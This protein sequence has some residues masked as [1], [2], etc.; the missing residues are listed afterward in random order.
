M[1]ELKLTNNPSSVATPEATR[2]TLYAVGDKLYY[3]DDA[4]N[5][6]G[7]LDAATAAYWFEKSLDLIHTTGSIE[8]T[9]SLAQGDGAQAAGLYTHAE[10][11]QTF[12]TGSYTHAE[13]EQTRAG[14]MGYLLDAATPVLPDGSDFVW[15]LDASYGNI[16]GTINSEF[17]DQGGRFQTDL[18]IYTF[19]TAS[20]NGTNTVITGSVISGVAAPGIGSTPT[21]IT[22]WGAVPPVGAD[23]QM[24]NYSHAEG[25][26]AYTLG[27]RSHAEGDGGGAAVLAIA[28]GAHAEGRRAVAAGI[29]SHAEGDT[30]IASGNGSHSEGVQVKASG[31]YSH[32]EGGDT[33]SYGHESHAEGYETRSGWLGYQ[34]IGSAPDGGDYAFQLDSSYQD[35]TAVIGAQFPDANGN[36]HTD[37]GQYTYVNTSW[38]GTNT[39]ITGSGTPP[40]SPSTVTRI[41]ASPPSRAYISMGFYSH[42]EGNS[43]IAFG[44]GSHAEGNGTIALGLYSHAEG[45]SGGPGSLIASGEYAHAEGYN[46][47]ASGEYSHAEGYYS[48]ASGPTSH[49]EGI[50]T[51][52]SGPTS[53]AEGSDTVALGAAA[54]AEGDHTLAEG[55]WSHSEGYYT[56][57]SGDYS[58][59]EGS[60]TTAGGNYTHAEGIFTFALGEGSHSEGIGTIASGTWQHVQGKYN[61]RNNDFSIFVIGDGVGDLDV[62]RS[63]IIRVNSGSTV[64]TGIVDITGSLSVSGSQSVLYQYGGVNYYPRIVTSITPGYT[65]SLTDYIIGVSSSLG[66]GIELAAS[67]FGKAYI[68]K[69]VSGSASTDNITVTAAGALINGSST[70]TINSDFGSAQFVYFG[71]DNGWGTI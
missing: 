15:I 53:H 11:Y 27:E 40:S 12:A 1:S 10:G 60:Y 13:G 64:G 30:T 67:Q 55:Q 45:G 50:S 20:F 36:F 46:T 22:R 14:F 3:K 24:G 56:T 18:G 38:D 37:E 35:I 9:G 2:V 34:L 26:S 4:G 54:H 58:H 6:T 39:W 41:G 43:T 68:I 51:L 63:D 21:V 19:F 59:A 5:E 16:A 31:D 71:P 23:Q 33:I 66:D 29:Y 47:L 42:A 49:A 70:Y 25:Y 69:D 52:A 17:P 32:A 8:I 28:S 65:S 57:G 62:D 44:R 48:I 7:P 61:T